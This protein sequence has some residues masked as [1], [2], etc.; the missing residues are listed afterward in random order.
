VRV[1]K[2]KRGDG[3]AIFAEVGFHEAAVDFVQQFRGP[4]RQV[5]VF[6]ERFFHQ[7]KLSFNFGLVAVLLLDL[8]SHVLDLSQVERRFVCVRDAFQE[9]DALYDKLGYKLDGGVGQNRWRER[10]RT[11]TAP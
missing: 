11:L 3:C 10:T 9:F 2:E 7:S 4:T 5:S 6:L 8:M 1:W